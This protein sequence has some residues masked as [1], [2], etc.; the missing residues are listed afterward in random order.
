MLWEDVF[1]SSMCERTPISVYVAAL[2]SSPTLQYMHGA[3]QSF[4]RAWVAKGCQFCELRMFALR[5]FTR[6]DVRITWILESA[7]TAP[8]PEL[9][10]LQ[11]C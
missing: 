11:L 3:A 5:I 6:E 4:P 7:S 10:G 1:C 2:H 8:A 9:Q